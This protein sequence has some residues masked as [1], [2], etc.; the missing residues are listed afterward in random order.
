MTQS[1]TGTQTGTGVSLAYIT[2]RIQ[3]IQVDAGVSSHTLSTHLSEI[4]AICVFVLFLFL[5]GLFKK[6][7][8]KRV[9]PNVLYPSHHRNILVYTIYIQ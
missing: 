5:K 9:Y 2:R 8:T 7:V 4:E 3:H 1:G 6:P